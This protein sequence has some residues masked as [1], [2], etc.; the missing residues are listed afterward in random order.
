MAW[1]KNKVNNINM[2]M[3]FLMAISGGFFINP[4]HADAN[5]VYRPYLYNGTDLQMVDR[6]RNKSLLSDWTKTPADAV[7]LV[8][9]FIAIDVLDHY[10]YNDF[11]KSPL[12]T[13][14]PGFYRLSRVDQSRVASLVDYVYH[15]TQKIPGTIFVA[16]RDTHRVIGLYTA[17][18]LQ[19][20]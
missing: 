16:D 12:L 19:L 9:N 13:V 10:S 11:T 18:G 15:G 3:I 14:G 6:V 5:L 1:F 4:V 20:E 2:L 7:R 8:Q 17:E